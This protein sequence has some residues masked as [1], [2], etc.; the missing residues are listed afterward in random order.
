VT[1]VTE[2]TLGDAGA[3]QQRDVAVEIEGM[4]VRYGAS[5]VIRD[6]SLSV[7]RGAIYGLAGASGSGKTTILR[8]LST[9]QQ[10][11][12]GIV[13]VEGVDLRLDPRSA[14]A[15]IGYLPDSFGVY[16]A[17]TVREYLD[18]CA[19]LFGV[20]SRR[21]RQTVDDLLELFRLGDERDHAAGRLSRG[22]KQ[23]LGMARCLVHDPSVLLLDEPA[24]AMDLRS[25]LDLQ[26]ILREL[27]R[28]GKTVLISSNLLPEL[29]DVC[30]YLGIVSE[31]RLAADGETREFLD[32]AYLRLTGEWSGK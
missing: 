4:S 1:A 24:A 30:T 29:A 23:Q 31:G 2:R 15:R 12:S 21:R 25:R 17:L 14:R 28:L 27:A 20:P 8:V 5:P 18:Y 3:E 16:G 26:D 10:P 32:E 19:A 22:M 13:R 9:L 6:L 11:D 7:P